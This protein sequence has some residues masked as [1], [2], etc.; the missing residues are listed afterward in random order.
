MVCC[1]FSNICGIW[2]PE[3]ERT[4]TLVWNKYCEKYLAWEWPAMTT[5]AESE[6]MFIN[7]TI[8]DIQYK[9]SKLG[10]KFYF[11]TREVKYSYEKYR[12]AEQLLNRAVKE[13]WIL[14][15]RLSP[16]INPPNWLQSRSKAPCLAFKLEIKALLECWQVCYLYCYL[17]K[18]TILCNLPEIPNYEA[19]QLVVGWLSQKRIIKLHY[20]SKK[21][22]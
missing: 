9:T 6:G 22:E 21:E 20:E 4:S 17:P 2:N 12:N 14:F 7:S 5:G 16:F 8:K 15:H 1:I 13:D 18:Q 19:L 10:T 11:S 3:K